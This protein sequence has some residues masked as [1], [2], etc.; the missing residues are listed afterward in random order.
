MIVAGNS[1]TV[2]QTFEILKLFGQPTPLLQ[3]LKH[4]ATTSKIAQGINFFEMFI[5]RLFN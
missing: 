5:F 1:T 2:L 3:E 4:N